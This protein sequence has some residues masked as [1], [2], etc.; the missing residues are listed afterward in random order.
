MENNENE[1]VR[2]LKKAPFHKDAKVCPDYARQY[3]KLLIDCYK[4]KVKK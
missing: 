4:Q 1:L 3:M 2:V